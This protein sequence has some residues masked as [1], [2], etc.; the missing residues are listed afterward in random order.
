[1]ATQIVSKVVEAIMLVRNPHTGT[2]YTEDEARAIVHGVYNR[3]RVHSTAR[4]G[5]VSVTV[6]KGVVSE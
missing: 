1:M 3:K 5:A 4:D 2:N 6:K